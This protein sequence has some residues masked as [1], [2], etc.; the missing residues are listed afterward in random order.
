M[1]LEPI[2]TETQRMQREIHVPAFFPTDSSLKQ[3]ADKTGND[4]RNHTKR[5]EKRRS[6]VLFRVRSWIVLFYRK[7]RPP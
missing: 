1:A 2:T 3:A 7:K 6:F 5:H 4:P